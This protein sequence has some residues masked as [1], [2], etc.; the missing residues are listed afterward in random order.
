MFQTYTLHLCILLTTAFSVLSSPQNPAS[1]YGLPS[2]SRFL[3]DSPRLPSSSRFLQNSP[4]LRSSSRFLQNSPVALRTPPF[5]ARNP[6][7][8]SG[9]PRDG[10]ELLPPLQ[11]VVGTKFPA[12]DPGPGYRFPLSQLINFTPPPNIH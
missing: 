1:S 2:S 9:L 8:V 6:Q 11:H 7:S 4:G 3:Q 10:L 12:V 5:P